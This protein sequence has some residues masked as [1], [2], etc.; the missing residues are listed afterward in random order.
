MAAA[1][2]F[3]GGAFDDLQARLAPIWPEITLRRRAGYRTLVVVSSLSIE[4]PASYQPLIAAYE[5]RYLI[6][7]LALATAPGT[8]VIYVTSQ[9]ILPRLVDY[10][11]DL[12][13]TADPNDIRR[14]LTTLSVGDPTLE[15]LTRKILDRPRMKERIRS[16]IQDES[17]AILIPFVTTDLEV[18][19][20]LELD[21]PI[22][23]TDPRLA[24]L[25]TKCGSRSVFETAG[26][27]HPR[28]R[29][30]L[31]TVDDLVAALVDLQAEDPADEAIV[32][33]DEGV[34]G[35]GNALVDLRGAASPQV[36]EERVR[37]L[38]PEDHDLDAETYLERLAE[39]GGIVEE[40]ICGDGF[41]SPSVQL[42]ISPE[43]EIEVLTT[44]DQVLGGSL[45]QTY[46]GCRFPA[47]HDYASLISEHAWRV[48]EVMRSHG[49]VGRFG[50]DFV[51]TRGRDGW[52]AYAVE[53]N[54]RSGGTTHPYLALH[55]LTEGTYD[56]DTAVFTANETAKHY[57][58]SDHIEAERLNTLTP[59][60]VLDVVEEAGLS[61]DHQT[62]TGTVLH[63]LSGVGV[64]GR[65]G[66]TAIGD[67]PEQAQA[68]FD[69]LEAALCE[70]V[71]TPRS[72]S[73]DAKH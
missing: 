54:L 68:L 51:V 50:I 3:D 67:T 34:S 12:I 2:D 6:Y 47:S 73:Q 41:A 42:R 61:W 70:A 9:P 66:A 46:F 49:V 64:A 45:G 35:A 20:A 33:L 22:Y 32:K 36:I 44:H 25:G 48:G 11:L 52:R 56:P 40:R 30:G 13:P 18:R 8:R 38:A 72:Q 62:R 21:L 5:E 71:V 26:V 16:L 55:A 60:D 10:Y 14:R 58:A 37:A 43:G 17:P 19:L 27:P 31:R 28:G 24:D 15:P 1:G 63:M 65:V 23:G 69:R 29:S 57:V 7:V 4:L 39:M 53:I 59:D